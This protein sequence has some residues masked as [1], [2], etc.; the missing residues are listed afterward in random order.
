MQY[1]LRCPD[2][3]RPITVLPISYHLKRWGSITVRAF[4][5]PLSSKARSRRSISLLRDL[6]FS[7]DLHNLR[8]NHSSSSDKHFSGSGAKRDVTVIR[9]A[10]PSSRSIL[11]SSSINI[12]Y[13]VARRAP[14]RVCSKSFRPL[15]LPYQFPAEVMFQIH[16]PAHPIQALLSLL[17]A[18]SKVFRRNHQFLTHCCAK[19]LM[20]WILKYISAPTRHL[21]HCLSCGILPHQI[22]FPGSRAQQTIKMTH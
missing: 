12:P 9:C 15:K 20:I 14:F 11:H 18:E 4:F 13:P 21:C 8:K 5:M 17:F 1:L 2:A 19:Y 3:T 22:N 10:R 16:Q 6:L 7:S